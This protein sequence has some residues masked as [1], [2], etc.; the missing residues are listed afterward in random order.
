MLNEAFTEHE[1]V[2]YQGEIDSTWEEW[3]KEN[4]GISA[5]RGRKIRVIASLL[6]PYPG[7]TKLGLSFSEVYSRR[8]QIDVMLAAPSQQ[9]NNYWRQA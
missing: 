6:A 2:K 9:W 7:L 3:L 4:V 8:K 5:P 1:L